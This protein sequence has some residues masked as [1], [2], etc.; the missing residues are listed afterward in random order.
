[1]EACFLSAIPRPILFSAVFG[2]FFS[3]PGYRRKKF[4]L[5][6]PVF[7]KAGYRK[8]INASNTPPV[9]NR[10][11]MLQIPRRSSTGTKHFKFPPQGLANNNTPAIELQ[12]C[13]NSYNYVLQY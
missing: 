2:S 11:K 5:Y 4:D 1:M 12:G 7:S 8:Q 9:F 10:Y 6:C 3:L 13:I